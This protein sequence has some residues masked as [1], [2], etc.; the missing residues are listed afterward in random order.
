MRVYMIQ[1][2]YL[3]G[4]TTFLPYSAGVLIAN[5][6]RDPALDE[7]YTFEEP[8]FVRESIN[9]ILQKI[10]RPAI[11]AFS[12][13]IWNHEYN[14]ALARRI[15]A[16][17]PACR[18]VFGG[19]HLSPDAKLLEEEPDVDILLFDEG[20]ETFALLLTAIMNGASFAGIPNLA[21]RENGKI[22]RTARKEITGTDYP[23]AYLSGVFDNI[24]SHY[25]NLSFHAIL[26]TN[27]GCPYTCAYCD[28]GIPPCTVRLFP[29]EKVMEEL[30]WFSDHGIRAFGAAD[31]NFGMFARDERFADEMI[32]LHHR[33]GVLQTFQ[34]SYAKQS[35]ERVFRITQKLN[36]CGM[37]KGATLSFQSLS[38][39]ALQNIRRKNLTVE[40]FSSLLAQY[41]AAGIATYTELILGLPGE[42]RQS[43]IEGIDT[44][45]N[46][47]QHNAIYIHN[48]EQ[49][50]F[51]AMGDA[52]FTEQYGIRASRLP[53]NQP[54][55]TMLADEIEE[56]SHIITSTRTM[57]TDDWIYMNLYSAVI[58]GFHH[59]GLLLCFALYLHQAQNV[60]YSAFYQDLIRELAAHP[61]TVAGQ[62]IARL[63]KQFQAAAEAKGGLV[64]QDAR[65]GNIGWPPEEYLL[66]SV[67]YEAE[68]FYQ[69]IRPFLA[70]YFADEQLLDA[71]LL[72]QQKSLKLPACTAEISFVCGYDFCS[73][74]R[75]LLCGQ[76][77]ALQ[78]RTCVYRIRSTVPYSTWPDYARYIIWYGRKDSRNIYLQEME[79]VRED[80]GGTA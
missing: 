43:F 33:Y 8:L 29:E 77:A 21:Y 64:M 7:Y 4:N 26:E 63:Q 36:A 18:I 78:K 74:F 2:N 30:R 62:A 1:I 75:R 38:A 32:R 34:A 41:N 25:P 28:S 44:L 66:L 55:R 40:S 53:L 12:N 54:H 22:I 61:E 58:Q 24:F 52:A 9:D 37:N 79:E 70:S 67:A 10:D 65:F 56:Y 16:Q 27:R 51:S 23:S 68:R 17:Y 72:Y 13:Y 35:N 11:V 14:K 46:A 48:C 19:H 31:A 6:R 73:Y 59:E 57:S 45:L 20:E 39:C 15:K 60:P 49:L 5:A 69:E 71:L 76:T 47:G 42:T 80:S 50:P 3:H